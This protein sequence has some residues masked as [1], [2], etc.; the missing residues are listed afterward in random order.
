MLHFS[1][2][3]GTHSM[4]GYMI[5]TAAAIDGLTAEGIPANQARAIVR[6]V[7]QRNEEVATMSDILAVKSDIR[8]LGADI[9]AIRADMRALESRLN[10]KIYLMAASVVAALKALEYLGI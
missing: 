8:G 9:R 4:A 1:E 2:Q 5:D 3:G 7:A 10:M 6:T